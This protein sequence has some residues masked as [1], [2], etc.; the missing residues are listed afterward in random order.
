LQVT[1]GLRFKAIILEIK[2]VFK[3]LKKSIH[4]KKIFDIL[5]KDYGKYLISSDKNGNS[6]DV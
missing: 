2:S 1:D 5:V 4:G 3:N 6:K